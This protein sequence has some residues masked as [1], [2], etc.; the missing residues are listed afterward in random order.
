MFEWFLGGVFQKSDSNKKF[1]KKINQI[2]EITNEI[3]N[4]KKEVDTLEYEVL[5]ENK[6]SVYISLD[7]FL[8]FMDKGKTLELK[9]ILS[10]FIH[11]DELKSTGKSAIEVYLIPEDNH[12][13]ICA[14]KAECEKHKNYKGDPVRITS[15]K[16][17]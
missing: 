10:S 15:I 14:D 2:S 13:V 5:L 8:K 7:Q 12:L 16:R 17:I 1:I 11:I 4:K 3:N 9:D 6:D